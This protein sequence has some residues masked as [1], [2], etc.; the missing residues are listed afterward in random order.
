MLGAVT[1]ID[2]RPLSGS[3]QKAATGSNE[4]IFSDADCG[5]EQPSKASS[6]QESCCDRSGASSNSDASVVA[7]GSAIS[8]QMHLG[9]VPNLLD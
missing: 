7:K 1:D 3:C 2:H 6:F 4:I 5:S 8:S 9:W